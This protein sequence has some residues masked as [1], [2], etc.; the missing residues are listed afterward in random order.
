M[1]IFSI[2]ILIIISISCSVFRPKSDFNEFSDKF[3][4][5]SFPFQIN[6]SLAF[7]SWDT[8]NLIDTNWVKRYELISQYADKKY[9]LKL[10]D[11]KCSRVGRYKSGDYIVFL[12]K[13]YTTEAGRG[14]PQI[15]LTTFTTKGEKKDETMV[16]WNDAEDPLYNQR[17]TLN[18]PNSDTLIVKSI[19]KTNGYLD[20]EIVPRKIT[21]KTIGYVI[22]NDGLIKRGMDATED[23]YTD[24]NPQILDDFPNE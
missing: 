12:Y 2:F 21:E 3:E 20:G 11:Y 7:E 17:V 6:D 4:A 18:I 13:T 16:L 5:I 23:I 1:K 10:Q 19:I 14:N 22:L 15:I 24:D 9:P 8:D